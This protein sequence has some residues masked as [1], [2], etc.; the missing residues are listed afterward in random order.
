MQIDFFYV[1]TKLR[2]VK[3]CTR[4]T[5]KKISFFKW[6]EKWFDPLFFDNLGSTLK[7]PEIICIKCMVNYKNIFLLALQV[8]LYKRIG[9]D[10]YKKG[11]R[12]CLN[13]LFNREKE[14]AKKFNFSEPGRYNKKVLSDR[15]QTVSMIKGSYS[16]FCWYFILNLRQTKNWRRRNLF[17]AR[18]L[19]ND[20][21]QLLPENFLRMEHPTR[22]NI[23]PITGVIPLMI[24]WQ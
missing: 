3:G 7:I 21:P 13:T 2:R 24:W 11:V 14:V 4:L 9:G 22:N 20:L 17:R 10:G 8:N 16:T 1:S 12:A 23:S 6:K 19:S 5:V 18:L 15:K